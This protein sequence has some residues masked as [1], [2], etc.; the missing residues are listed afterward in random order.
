MY[1]NPFGNFLCLPLL[2]SHFSKSQSSSFCPGSCPCTSKKTIFF[3]TEKISRILSWLFAA[4]PHIK[5]HQTLPPLSL[6]DLPSMPSLCP[7]L[8]SSL[9]VC[10]LG[11]GNCFQ[12]G[13]P[14]LKSQL[15]LMPEFFWLKSAFDGAPGWLSQL[16]VWLWLR[17]WSHSPWVQAPCQA[18]WWQLRAWSLLWIL[19]LPLSLPLLRK[20]SISPS[21]SLS[22]SQK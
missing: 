10:Y 6:V 15:P 2:L 9:S 12:F 13:V 17:S 14:D 3:R 8:G 5:W 4:R 1:E 18:L 19:C 11:K 16:S 7:W 22:L 21:P 20:H